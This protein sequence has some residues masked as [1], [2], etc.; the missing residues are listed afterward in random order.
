MTKKDLDMRKIALLATAGLALACVD[1][2]SAQTIV[3]GSSPSAQPRQGLPTVLRGT[4]ARAEPV[5]AEQK[6]ARVMVTGGRVLW[7]IDPNGGVEGCI[8]RGSGYVDRDV[9]V[10]SSR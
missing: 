3:R 10:C 8:L 7:L 1:T 9:V 4:S 5:V 2:A 6:P